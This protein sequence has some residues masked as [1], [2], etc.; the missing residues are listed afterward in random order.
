MGVGISYLWLV[1]VKVYIYSP[2][3]AIRSADYIN[4]LQIL[5]HALPQSSPWGECSPSSA[6]EMIHNVPYFIPPGTHFCLG[7][8]GGVNSKFAHDFIHD[9]CC[10]NK[11]P[12]PLISGPT[13]AVITRSIFF[14]NKYLLIE[15]ELGKNKYRKMVIKSSTQTLIT[16]KQNN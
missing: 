1:K 4:Y 6:A 5:E 14:S 11:I 15:H 8:R 2:D 7:P 12:D 9:H 16:F 13:Y 3:I 10:G